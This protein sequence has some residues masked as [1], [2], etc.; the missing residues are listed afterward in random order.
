MPVLIECILPSYQC[1]ACNKFITFTYDQFRAGK[2]ECRNPDCNFAGELEKFPRFR[3]QNVMGVKYI[4]CRRGP[5]DQRALCEIAIPEHAGFLQKEAMK[6]FRYANPPHII[7]T[8]PE[9]EAY[10]ADEEKYAGYQCPAPPTVENKPITKAVVGDMTIEEI[11]YKVVNHPKF[12]E[13]ITGV[14]KMAMKPE[15]KSAMKPEAKPAM[16]PEAK[17]A[18]KPEGKMAMTSEMKEEASQVKQEK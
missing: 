6:G 3:E 14:V 8:A 16:N 5:H 18:M 7:K 15:A 2:A 12:I 11:V 17:P 4:F 13:G 9:W 1:P 10:R